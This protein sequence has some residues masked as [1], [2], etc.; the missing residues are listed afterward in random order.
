MT[1]EEPVT[2]DTELEVPQT[3]TPNNEEIEQEIENNDQ[4]ALVRVS[5]W[6]LFLNPCCLFSVFDIIVFYPND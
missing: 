2:I 6:V 3:V 1:I 4:E 5:S